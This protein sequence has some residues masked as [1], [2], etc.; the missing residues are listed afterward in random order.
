MYSVS[1][2]MSGYAL[3]GLLPKTPFETTSQSNQSYKRI[4]TITLVSPPQLKQRLNSRIP[5]NSYF[6]KYKGT[7]FI[8]ILNCCRFLSP[9]PKGLG[10]IGLDVRPSVCLSVI[11][12]FV[13][14]RTSE[15]K[16]VQTRKWASMK[17]LDV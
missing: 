4:N 5:N 11:L 1:F 12:F 13:Q 6:P 9:N 8:F 15:W 3:I 7:F 16:V 10:P 17:G 14:A 2:K